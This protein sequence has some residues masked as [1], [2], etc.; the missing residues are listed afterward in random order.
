MS[1]KCWR[2]LIADGQPA[3]HARIGKIFK[4][5]GCRE[6]TRVH[7]FRELL[8]V[9]HYS[10]EPF[11]HFDLMIINAEMLAAAGVDCVRFFASNAQIRHGVIHDTVRGQPQAQTIYA[12]HRRQLMLI[13]TPDR[14]TLGP[15]LEHLDVQEQSHNL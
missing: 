5:L 10:S 1:Y 9:T 12:N 13:R 14:H 6:L 2:I 8:G 3:L 15:L 11:Q 4:E 7:S